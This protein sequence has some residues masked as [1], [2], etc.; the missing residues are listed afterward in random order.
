V[1]GG[2]R[3]ASPREQE[4]WTVKRRAMVMVAALALAGGACGGDDDA[5]VTDDAAATSD[6]SDDGGDSGDD[7]SGGGEWCD[8]ARNVEAEMDTF[9]DV[10]F[11]DPESLEDAYQ[12]MIDEVEDAVDSA[13]DEIEDDLE[14]IIDGF[15]ELFEA[16]Q[17]V[18]FDFLELDQSVLENSEVEAASDR[19]EAYNERECGIESDSDVTDDTDAGDDTDSGDD[20][21]L[22]GEGTIRDEMVRQ[23]TAMGM[24]EDQANCLVDNIDLEEVASSGAADPSMFFDLFETCEIELT[25]LQ[26]DG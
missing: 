8:M 3:C 4:R 1:L 20:D 17:D 9:E 14:L 7:G 21:T 13:P 10:D 11:T 2:T 18:D 23:F 5:D 22:S 24:T 25:D 12:Q 19:I 16:L 15:K 26:P 6:A